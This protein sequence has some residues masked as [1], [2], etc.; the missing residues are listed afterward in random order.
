VRSSQDR[1]FGIVESI[2]PGRAT[3]SDD[4][5]LLGTV[6]GGVVGAAVGHQVGDGRTND[7]ATVAGAVGGAVVGRKIDQRHDRKDDGYVIG[8]RL[9][10][11]SRRTIT[12]ESVDGLRVGDNMRIGTD[13]VQRF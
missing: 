7:V 4:S 10:D 5:A 6:I 12:Q 9:N 1:S 8:V 3:D 2:E 13:G 11:G